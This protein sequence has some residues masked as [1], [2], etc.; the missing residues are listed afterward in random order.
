MDR[1]QKKTH[2]GFRERQ[3]PK[4]KIQDC[5]RLTQPECSVIS[6]HLK[7]CLYRLVLSLNKLLN[8]W[9]VATYVVIA[10]WNFPLLKWEFQLNLY[11]L[12]LRRKDG[13]TPLVARFTSA[14]LSSAFPKCYFRTGSEGWQRE[15]GATRKMMRKKRE[16]LLGWW[17]I[18]KGIFPK[19]PCNDHIPGWWVLSIQPDNRRFTWN[20]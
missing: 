12:F 3:P 2:V 18:S 15:G 1:K 19:W 16:T 5:F 20:T 4:I 8:W 9:A 13:P 11:N 7:L 6:R 14:W 10:F 17:W